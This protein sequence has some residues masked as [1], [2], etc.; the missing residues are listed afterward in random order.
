MFIPNKSFIIVLSSDSVNDLPPI[1]QSSYVVSKSA[2]SALGKSLAVE[3]SKK[4]IKVNIIEPGMIDTKLQIKFQKLLRR[5]IKLKTW[6]E[7]VQKSD[8]VNFIKY[9]IKILK[10]NLELLIGLIM[11][12]MKITSMLKQNIKILIELL[13]R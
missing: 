4:G 5:L 8:I 7:L 1:Y 2:L 11:K 6:R 12:E 9:L 10:N 13:K 3:Y